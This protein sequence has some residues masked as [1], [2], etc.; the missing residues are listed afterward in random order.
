M[1]TVSV[2]DKGLVVSAEKA[3]RNAGLGLNPVTEGQTCCASR[4]RP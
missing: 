2:W 1:I 3:I 4:S